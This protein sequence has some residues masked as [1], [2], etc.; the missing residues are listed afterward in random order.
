MKKYVTK[1]LRGILLRQGLTKFDGICIDKYIYESRSK[2][3]KAIRDS[4]EDYDITHFILYVRC[5]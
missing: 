3:Y 2:Y 5:V 1:K 4:E